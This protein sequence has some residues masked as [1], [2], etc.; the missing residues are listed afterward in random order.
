M[1]QGGSPG[2]DSAWPAAPG[3]TPEMAPGVAL[4]DVWT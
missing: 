1:R 4:E 3:W 2:S